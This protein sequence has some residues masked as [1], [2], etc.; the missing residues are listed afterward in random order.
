[1]R[2]SHFLRFSF[3]LL[4][5]IF[6]FT[7][8]IEGDK[9]SF[10]L[11][12]DLSIGV[13]Y[14]DQNLMFGSVSDIQL[15]VEENIYIL[16]Y[17]N[18]RVQIFD[19]QGQFLKSIPLKKGQGPQ[20]ISMLRGFAV[21]PDGM[22]S[23]FDGGGGKVVNYDKKGK[24]HNS[25]KLDFQTMD[26][27]HYKKGKLAVLGLKHE[28]IIHIYNRQG[29][30]LS[31][32]AEPFPVPSKLSQ[33]KDVPQSKFPIRFDSSGKGKIFL[34]NPHKFE[35]FIYSDGQLSGKIK[36]KSDFFKPMMI[37]ASGKGEEKRMSIVFPY[38]S[39]LECQ[40]KTVVTIRGIGRLGEEVEN[41]MQIFEN[42]KLLQSMKV[43]GFP[44]A[45]DSEGRLYFSGFKEG[46]PV[47]KRYTLRPQ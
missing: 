34:L 35:I 19:P 47:L 28:Q 17:K 25:F 21:H 40:G 6:L 32:F 22:L 41:Q 4:G 2:N 42:R 20:E 7:G 23:F 39:V 31:S 1:M 18:F 44:Y 10:I 38:A 45:V 3:I 33:Y 43:K 46:F 13:G 30:L 27:K 8:M 9:K 5:L 29:K 14:G 26:I 11:E 12:E 24:Y 37:R 16:D 36:G 15:D